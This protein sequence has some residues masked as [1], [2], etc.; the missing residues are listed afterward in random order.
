MSLLKFTA[1]VL[2]CTRKPLKT[3]ICPLLF[4]LFNC[5][6]PNLSQA[7]IYFYFYFN[8]KLKGTDHTM[9]QCDYYTTF[10]NVCLAKMLLR[11]IQLTFKLQFDQTNVVWTLKYHLFCC[12][13]QQHSTLTTFQRIFTLKQIKNYFNFLHKNPI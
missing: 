10:T 2:F 11:E 1:K 13:D 4:P 12:A 5:N 7:H 9:C 6:P 3:I 8:Y